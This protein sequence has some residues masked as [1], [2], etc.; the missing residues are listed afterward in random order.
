MIKNYCP[1][2]DVT[3]TKSH[4]LSFNKGLPV[5]INNVYGRYG[6]YTLSAVVKSSDTDGDTCGF[7]INYNDGTAHI[8]S[9]ARSVDSER[10][11][12]AFAFH[13]NTDEDKYIESILLYAGDN[14]ANSEGDTAT[15]SK[16]MISWGRDFWMDYIPYNK[17]YESPYSE[18]SQYILCLSAKMPSF[19]LPNPTSK[20]SF[21]LSNFIGGSESIYIEPSNLLPTSTFIE[22]CLYSMCMVYGLCDYDSEV[23]DEVF[24]VSEFSGP[25]LSDL[26]FYILNI[27]N[28]FT[29]GAMSPMYP[30][31]PSP[32]DSELNQVCYD[33]LVY[34]GM[35][36]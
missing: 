21:W 8:M 30:S 16:I 35:I 5:D 3:F 29:S 32:L 28:S 9:I 27:F 14:E 11:N 6:T 12:V 7:I 25:E 36:S 1:I 18:I 2:G 17:D 33:L 13:T 24:A 4:L 34:Y 26:E 15:F 31:I 23:Y 20:I 22:K 10:S 19:D